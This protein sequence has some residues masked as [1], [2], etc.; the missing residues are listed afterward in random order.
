MPSL[1]PHFPITH[2]K[3]V[4]KD[5]VTGQH[6]LVSYSTAMNPTNPEIMMFK[7]NGVGKIEDW[8]EIYGEWGSHLTPSDIQKVVNRYN[9]GLPSEYNL[10]D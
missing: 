4:Y 3:M 8:G 10:R 9:S 7:C 2:S 6:V 1:R 5:A